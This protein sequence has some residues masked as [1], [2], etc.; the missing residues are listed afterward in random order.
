MPPTNT[1]PGSTPSASAIGIGSPR[2]AHW[3][4][5]MPSC[6]GGGIRQARVSWPAIIIRLTDQLVHDPS[7]V[8][9]MFTP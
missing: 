5:M 9:A 4:R 6:W 8:L 2:A 7:G 3:D 1:R